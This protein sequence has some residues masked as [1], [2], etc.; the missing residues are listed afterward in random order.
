M[1]KTDME[2][3]MFDHTIGLLY[4]WHVALMCQMPMS[5]GNFLMENV[6]IK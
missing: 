5:Y 3:H 4:F 1:E 2:F 6:K